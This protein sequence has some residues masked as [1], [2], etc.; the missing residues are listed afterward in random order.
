MAIGVLK[1]ISPEY[2]LGMAFADIK[3]SGINGLRPYL[4]ENANKKIDFIA[5]GM[6]I[7]SGVG[8]LVGAA[9]GKDDGSNKAVNFL[10]E[11]LSECEFEYKDMLKGSESAK[12]VIAFKYKD[13]MEGTVDISMIKQDKE[14]KIDTLS[15]PHFDKFALPQS[16]KA[17][18]EQGGAGNE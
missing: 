9:S 3:K 18:N 17:E 5:A 13:I 15:M 10:I 8:K 14:W 11:K 7:V 12:A 1:K 4:T 2:V 6:D 16:E